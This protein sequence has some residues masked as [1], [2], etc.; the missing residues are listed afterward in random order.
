MPG[1][2]QVYSDLL[3]YSMNV[4]CLYDKWDDGVR[5]CATYKFQSLQNGIMRKD[6]I[7]AKSSVSYFY[8]I[9]FRCYERYEMSDFV[10]P[11]GAV[12][13]HVKK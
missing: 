6:L 13:G 3:W 9:I 4:P 1:Y 7:R 10:V 2:S 12:W 8:K 11:T 5:H